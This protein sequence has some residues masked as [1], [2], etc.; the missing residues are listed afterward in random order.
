MFKYK[1]THYLKLQLQHLK[2]T[3][4]H[5]ALASLRVITGNDV[6]SGSLLGLNA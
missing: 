6:G 5:G 3:N 1:I 4:L 2:L